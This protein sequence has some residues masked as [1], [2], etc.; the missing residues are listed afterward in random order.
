MI[1]SKFGG[2]VRV[3]LVIITFFSAALLVGC[4]G[5][6][7]SNTNNS[8][9][10]NAAQQRD[11]VISVTPAKAEARQIPSYIQTTGSL[12]ADETSEVASKVA[13]KVTNTFVNVGQFVQQGTVLAKLDEN[14]AKLQVKQAE[15]GIAQAQAAVSQAQARLGLS[16]TGNFQA[17]EIPEVRA[18]NAN[19]EQALA[20]LRQAEA[21]EKR[22]HDLVETGDTSMQTYETYRTTRDTARAQVNA[23]KQQLEAAVNAAKQNNQAIKSA[24]AGVDSA[25]AQ[26]ATA[27]QAVADTVIRAPFSGFVS[28]RQISVGE[29][30]TTANPIITLLRTNPIKIQI[31]TTAAEVPFIHLG[32]SVSLQVDAFKDRKFAGTITAVNPSVDPTSR[33]A[34][35]EAQVENNE[36]LLRA[37]MFATVQIVRPGGG[38]GVFVP[39]SAVYNDQNTQSYRSF[40]IQDGVAKLRVVQIGQQENDDIQILSGLNDGEIVAASNLP[41]LYEG[42]KVRIQ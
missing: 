5:R 38:Q 41:Q 2:D 32:T 33:T 6:S 13:G 9:Q 3:R 22:Y 17:G 27:R 15:A 28:N 29:F 34:I 21:N 7:K 25:R 26:A 12:V 18:A 4:S 19:Y 42:A 1:L 11:E 14:A 16:A 24:Q 31:Q 20:Q 39:K 37:G 23:V 8:E 30:V 40:V 10:A 35:V 36:N